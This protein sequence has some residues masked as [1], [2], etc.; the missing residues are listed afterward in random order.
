MKF[1]D[2]L[3]RIYE[4]YWQFKEDIWNLF[5]IISP[6]DQPQIINNSEKGTREKKYPDGR[7]EIWYSN[8]NRY[9]E[10]G[11]AMVTGTENMVQQW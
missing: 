7:V 4:I 10:N 11:T 6:Q 3:K 8:G 5:F 1:I 2:N 9:R